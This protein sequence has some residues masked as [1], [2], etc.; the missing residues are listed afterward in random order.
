M[1]QAN[2]ACIA[3]SLLK[4]TVGGQKAL[5]I[6]I[7]EFAISYAGPVL[8]IR[9]LCEGADSENVTAQ[10]A[11]IVNTEFGSLEGAGARSRP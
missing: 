5:K 7:A 11:K 10:A 4:D 9:L 8:L 6:L 3:K 1:I 2:A